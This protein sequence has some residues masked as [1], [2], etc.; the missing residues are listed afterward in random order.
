MNVA[1]QENRARL[2]VFGAK[3]PTVASILYPPLSRIRSL[4]TLLSLFCYT[5]ALKFDYAKVK[6]M[7]QLQLLLPL[8]CWSISLVVEQEIVYVTDLSIFTVLVSWPLTLS[9]DF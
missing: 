9:L 8:A 5:S 4:C 6:I 1:G 7:P 2:A 3:E